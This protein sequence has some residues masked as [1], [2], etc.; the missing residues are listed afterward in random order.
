MGVRMTL[1]REIVG[2]KSQS[3]ADRG[4]VGAVICR[5]RSC[6]AS[7][8]AGAAKHGAVDGVTIVVRLDG[9]FWDDCL[10]N[11]EVPEYPAKDS[12]RAAATHHCDWG[13]ALL[14]YAN[15]RTDE[16]GDGGDM[17]DDDG[18]VCDQR[19]EIVGT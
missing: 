12:G 5:R 17:L 14:V 2:R 1:S 8:G 7:G 10:T 11:P 13:N 9:G 15:E 6:C 4:G 19:P 3:E 18:R 16:Y